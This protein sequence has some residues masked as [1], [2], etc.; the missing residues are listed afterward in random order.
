MGVDDETYTQLDLDYNHIGIITVQQ[1]IDIFCN[2]NRIIRLS[3]NNNE[4]D[5]TSAKIITQVAHHSSHLRVISFANNNNIDAGAVE[6]VK[7]LQS[8]NHRLFIN[9]DNNHIT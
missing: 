1:N 7:S 3:L 6:I 4:I 8:I 2:P 9:L 5:D